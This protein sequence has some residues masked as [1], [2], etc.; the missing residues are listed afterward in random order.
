VSVVIW[1]VY[2][3]RKKFLVSFKFFNNLPIFEFYL[4]LKG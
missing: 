1:T 3:K 4:N 2:K